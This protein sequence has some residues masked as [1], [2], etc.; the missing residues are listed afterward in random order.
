MCFFV[1][2]KTH[3]KIHKTKR[4]NVPMKNYEKKQNEHIKKTQGKNKTQ[5]L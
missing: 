3:T 5:P 4:E 2:K 1:K